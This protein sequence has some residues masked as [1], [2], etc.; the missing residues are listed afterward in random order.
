MAWRRY[1]ACQEP[2]L[3]LSA[4]PLAK[5]LVFAPLHGFGKAKAAVERLGRELEMVTEVIT[6]GKDQEAAAELV[7]SFDEPPLEASYKSKC[8]VML[9]AYED[10]A[11][12]N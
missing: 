2:P 11:G 10:G 1:D 12:L 9:L 8:R 6:P 3:C 7:L 5:V 4:E